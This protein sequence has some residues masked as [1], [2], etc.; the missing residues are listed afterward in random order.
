MIVSKYEWGSVGSVECLYHERER[1]CPEGVRVREIAHV[2]YGMMPL[3]YNPELPITSNAGQGRAIP[4]VNGANRMLLR[5]LVQAQADPR[6]GS[7]AF[8]AGNCHAIS[9]SWKG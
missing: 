6:V 9:V 2:H 1:L 4:A 5:L 3:W 7:G 8:L